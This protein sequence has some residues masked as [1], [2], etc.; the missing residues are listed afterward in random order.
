MYL[1]HVSFVHPISHGGTKTSLGHDTPGDRPGQAQPIIEVDDKL[2][3]VA[4]ELPHNGTIVTRVV[5]MSNVASFVILEGAELEKFLQRE[6][7][8]KRIPATTP[9]P[10]AKK[11]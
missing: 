8:K 11:K 4:I 1:K 10:E 2:R 6:D 7:V 9:A 5:P 3:L